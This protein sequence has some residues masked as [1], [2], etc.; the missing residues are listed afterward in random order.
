MNLAYHV[1]ISEYC[2]HV[3]FRIWKPNLDLKQKYHIVN[4]KHKRK[5]EENAE[6]RLDRI[7]LCPAHSSTSIAHTSLSSFFYSLATNDIILM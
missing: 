7:P 2:I 3:T 4:K 5:K 1:D 6:S